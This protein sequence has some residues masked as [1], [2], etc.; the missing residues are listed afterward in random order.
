[1]VVPVHVF[2][3]G[4]FNVVDSAPWTVFVDQFS[5]VHPDGG[6]DQCVIECV[7]DQADRRLGPGLSEPVREGA[8]AKLARGENRAG[9][10]VCW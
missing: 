10:T 4:Q 9:V 8:V 7:A 5:L 1:M 2:Q 3:C 6:I